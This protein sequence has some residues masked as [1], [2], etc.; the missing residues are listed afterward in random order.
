MRITGQIDEL[1]LII[2]S[3]RFGWFQART[4]RGNGFMAVAHKLLGIE[5]Q[6]WTRI[7]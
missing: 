6:M 7:A 4:V 2:V 1:G 5:M 3:Q